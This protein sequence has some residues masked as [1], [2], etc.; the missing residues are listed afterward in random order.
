MKR[1]DVFAALL[2]HGGKV[3]D[4][5]DAEFAYAPPYGPAVDP[6]YS[7]ACVA[8]NEFLEGVEALP[9]DTAIDDCLIV[10]VRRS[11][12]ASKKPLPETNTT[13]VPLRSSGSFAIKCRKIRT[14][15]ASAPKESVRQKP[16]VSSGRKGAQRSNTWRGA[17]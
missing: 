10:D 4:L 17:L 6:L 16:S 2:K 12:E 3:A 9:P 11:K 14:W 7:L 8:R 15:C 1:I 13:N 5:L